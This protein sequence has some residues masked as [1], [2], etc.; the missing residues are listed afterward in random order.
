[1]GT[2][3]ELVTNKYS[4][5]IGLGLAA[6]AVLAGVVAKQKT[7]TIAGNAVYSAAFGVIIGSVVFAIRDSKKVAETA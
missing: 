4:K 6:L 3:K 1:M 5:S 2:V 7:M